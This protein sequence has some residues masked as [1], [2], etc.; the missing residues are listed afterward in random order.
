MK[1]MNVPLSILD[2]VVYIESKHARII[3]INH[4]HHHLHWHHLHWH[5]LH[6]HH[7]HWHHL[8]WHHHW[9]HVKYLFLTSIQVINA[10]TQ[11]KNGEATTW[12]I[13]FW[14]Q[15]PGGLFHMAFSFSFRGDFLPAVH[16]PH[17]FSAVEFGSLSHSLRPL[18]TNMFPENWWLE[19][20]SCPFKTVPFLRGLSFIFGGYLKFVLPRSLPSKKSIS[21]PVEVGSL[22]HYV[23]PWKLTH[24]WKFKPFQNVPF[25]GGLSF[26]FRVVYHYLQVVYPINLQD[27]F[28]TSQ[29]RVCHND[30]KQP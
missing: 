18:K 26:N 19:D 28:L 15:S 21:S 14:T 4:H 13:K 7:L 3:I 2:G 30:L 11:K 9:H 23:S 22:S 12:K 1:C 25:F 6:W 29:L 5:H 17:I 27:F 20:D 10:R 8:H 24:F 16:F